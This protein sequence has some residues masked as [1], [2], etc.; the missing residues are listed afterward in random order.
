MLMA[1]GVE[2]NHDGGLELLHDLCSFDAV[3]DVVD[4]ALMCLCGFVAV[5][6]DN[7]G[8]LVSV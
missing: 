4:F 7:L 1:G 2:L 3:H 5:H 8:I 6:T